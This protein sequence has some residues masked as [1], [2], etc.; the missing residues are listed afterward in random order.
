MLDR[1]SFLAT[2]AG[3]LAAPLL[4]DERKPD[5]VVALVTDSH[6][7]K[8]GADYVKRLRDTVAEINASPAAFTFF[9]GDLVDNGGTAAGQ[10]LYPEWLEIAKGLKQG[11]RAVP[12]NHDPRDVFTKHVAT[13]TDDAVVQKGYRFVSFAN[14]EPNP[15]HM[16]VVTPEQAKSLAG[17]FAEAAKKGERVVL[18][19]HVAYHENKAPDVGWYVTEGR[20]EFGKLLAANKQVVAYFSGHLHCG[21]RGWSDTAHGVHEVVLPCV[22]YNNDRKLDM[23]PGFA[24]KEFRPAWVLSEFYADELVL[25]YKPVGAE[26]ATSK[27]LPLKG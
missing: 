22:S 4:A 14:A 19:A 8:P 17:E 21:M 2:T 18:I 1:R 3:V 15:G 11:F 6:I 16:G 23:A 5:L 20:A 10:K 9:C 27:S 7:G 13:K 26:I 25:K 24:V 12:G